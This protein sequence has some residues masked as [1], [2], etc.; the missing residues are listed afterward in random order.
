MVMQTS[1]VRLKQRAIQ[2]NP[3]YEQLVHLGVSQEQ[4]KKKATGMPDG[5][6][7]NV[8]SRLQL[9]MLKLKEEVSQGQAQAK[10]R[11]YGLRVIYLLK[12]L[13]PGGTNCFVHGKTYN[14]CQVKGHYIKSSKCAKNKKTLA[15]VEEVSSDTESDDC[16]GKVKEEKMG[17]LVTDTRDTFVGVRSIE[18]PHLKYKSELKMETNTGCG[19]TTLNSKDWEKVKGNIKL[20]R[21]RRKFRPYGTAATFPVMG[22]A[23]VR[24]RARAGASTKTTVYV[25]TTAQTTV[26]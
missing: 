4:A 16:L 13:H 7:D 3:T 9:D 18:Y 5:H 26:C 23:E 21:T 11:G 25:K 19:K 17:R 24:L 6:K 12:L 1:S 2:E 15:M 8:I 10:G 20:K 14:K 22:R